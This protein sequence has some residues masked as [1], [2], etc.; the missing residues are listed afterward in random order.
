MS[1]IEATG[2]AKGGVIRAKTLSAK[3]RREIGE[4]AAAARWSED[5]KQVTHGSSDHP[6]KIGDV[7]IPCYVL[8]DETRVL[9]QRGVVAALG[10]KYGSRAGGADR[11]TG[12]MSGKGLSPFASN[13]LLAL[14]Q[15]PIKFRHQGGGGIAF[16]YPATILAD[17]CDAVLAARK[18]GA[19]Q[20][21][22]E[23]IAEQCEILVRGFARVGIIA[24]V[25]EATGYQK[26]R[27]KDALAKI[28]EAFIDKELQPWVQTFPNEFYQEMFRLRGLDYPTATV[29][30]PQYFGVLTNNV[31]YDRIAP[32]VLAE[33]RRVVPKLES[34]RRKHHY[35]RKLTTNV[36]YPKLKEHLGSVIAFMQMSKDWADFME[37]MDRFKPKYGHTMA[38]PLDLPEDDGKGL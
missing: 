27:A 7:E 26:D 16:G 4:K 37:K 13:D 29:K 30:R 3:R 6:L 33:L 38:L 19:L 25:D 15:A 35:F 17:I 24:L 14:I 22:Q 23:H 28:L 5:V 2:K 11:L 21:Q 8:E 12:F 18:A 9:S 1:E 20:K 36:G 34:G 31:V 10:M 32:G